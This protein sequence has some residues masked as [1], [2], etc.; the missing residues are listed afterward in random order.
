MR[1]ILLRRNWA[2]LLVAAMLGAVIGRLFPPF[3][4]DHGFWREFFLSSALGGLAAVAAAVIAY[5]A[6]RQASIRS[7][8]GIQA[9]EWWKQFEWVASIMKTGDALNQNLAL[10]VL[11]LLGK[12]A[13]DDYRLELV[14]FLT[15]QLLTDDD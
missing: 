13:A 5:A 12:E 1:W 4:L 11:A 8:Q 3:V 9:Q 14:T 15:Q 6:S 7:L 10:S 2:A